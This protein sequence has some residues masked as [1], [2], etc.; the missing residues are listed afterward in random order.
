MSHKPLRYLNGE[1]DKSSITWTPDGLVLAKHLNFHIHKFH[2]LH[3]VTN[4]CVQ[5]DGFCGLFRL[6]SKTVFV[7]YS[8][9]SHRIQA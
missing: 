1:G 5:E 2:C 3:I 9:E 8:R 6:E 4:I 7:I